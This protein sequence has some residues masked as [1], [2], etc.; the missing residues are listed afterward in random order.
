MAIGFARL[1]FVKRSEGKTACAKA[2]YNARERMNFVGNE[3]IKAN[4]YDWSYME[5]PIYDEVLLPKHVN[6]KFKNKETLWNAVELKETR[7]NSQ[8]AI[9]MV[10]ALPDDDAITEED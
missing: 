10:I 5:K 2:A 8:T 4:T 7:I 6:E 9:D 1:E 3:Y